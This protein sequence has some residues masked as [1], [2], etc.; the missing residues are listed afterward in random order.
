SKAQQEDEDMK[1][2]ADAFDK[3]KEEMQRIQKHGG[4]PVDWDSVAKSTTRTAVPETKKNP[5]VDTDAV[6]KAVQELSVKNKDAIF[7]Q[8]FEAWQ[9]KQKCKKKAESNIPTHP[10]I[11]LASLKAFHRTT[12][13]AKQATANLTRSATLAESLSPLQRGKDAVSSCSTEAIVTCHNGVYHEFLQEARN[14]NAQEK[15]EGEKIAPDLAVAFNAGIWGYQE[16]EATIQYL[17]LHESSLPA[18]PFV[19]TAYTLSECREDCSVISNA[20][21]AGGDNNDGKVSTPDAYKAQVLWE[22]EENPFGSHVVRDT[23]SSDD[24]YRENSCWQAWL[25]GG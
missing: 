24:E 9:R 3:R 16:W 4:F 13:K 20:V 10:L 15:T 21:G 7:H 12:A 6:K 23:K 17:A 2:I 22:P 8:K 11:P 14:N 5:D 18:I 1:I 19:I 25:L